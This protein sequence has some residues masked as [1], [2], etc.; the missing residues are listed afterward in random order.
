VEIIE[1]IEERTARIG[2]IGLG[3]VGLPLVREFVKAGFFVTGFDN[4][5]QKVRSL[6]AAKSYIKHIPSDMIVDMNR[7]RRFFPTTD[8]SK[9]KTMTCIIICVPTPLEGKGI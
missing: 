9:L 5:Q 3:Y 1:K 8:F 2:I 4:D 7:S 6:K